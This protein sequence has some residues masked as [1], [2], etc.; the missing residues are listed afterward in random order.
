MLRSL[1]VLIFL[2]MLFPRMSQTQSMLEFNSKAC[3]SYKSA[4]A[5]L[6]QLYSQ[7]LRAKANE[8]NF[9]AAFQVAQKFMGGVSR[10]SRCG[11]LRT[12][13]RT[14]TA[15]PLVAYGRLDAGCQCQVL[16]EMTR[17]RIKEL[18]RRWVLGTLEDDV[19]AGT[20]AQRKDSKR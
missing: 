5:T 10:C 2:S 6:K 13:D 7:I 14:G 16:E 9:V 8:R 1:L 12:P 15:D 19:C 18:K 4:D 20:S 11:Y 17:Q 3:D